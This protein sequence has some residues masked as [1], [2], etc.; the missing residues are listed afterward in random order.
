M[1]AW[2]L[3]EDSIA[4]AP[5]LLGKRMSVLDVYVAMIS[6]WRPGRAWLV[7]HC[8]KAMSAVT[9]TEAVPS[10]AATWSRNFT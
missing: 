9:A 5:F 3:F 6:R 1:H 4:P 10:I 2:R 8:P 7:E